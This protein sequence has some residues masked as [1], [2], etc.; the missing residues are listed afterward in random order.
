[1]PSEVFLGGG[2]RLCSFKERE[3]CCESVKKELLPVRQ[4]GGKDAFRREGKKN[5]IFREM[6]KASR[7]CDG[8]GKKVK[9]D[10]NAR[11]SCFQ[12][13]L[14]G[15]TRGGQIKQSHWDKKRS[16]RSFE[17]K[18]GE[19][20]KRGESQA[21]VTGTGGASKRR[22]RKRKRKLKITFPRAGE[23][24]GGGVPLPLAERG[25]AWSLLKISGLERGGRSPRPQPAD[26][27]KGEEGKE[28]SSLA[29]DERG[30]RCC[31]RGTSENAHK[32]ITRS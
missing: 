23:R 18:E 25:H 4:R 29:M 28:R 13:F 21:F 1:V 3:L 6:M 2:K 8:E 27:G 11:R 24:K 26:W 31:H 5:P 14:R 7:H 19:S 17:K 10:G 9:F 16:H 30:G 15:V 12:G 32:P 22:P 20:E